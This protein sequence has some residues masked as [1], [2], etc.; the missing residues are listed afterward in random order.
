MA[1][2]R[3]NEGT[4]TRATSR[5]RLASA[6]VRA[7]WLRPKPTPRFWQPP[8][9]AKLATRKKS[10]TNGRRWQSM[11]ALSRKES[12][13]SCAAVLPLGARSPLHSISNRWTAI[14]TAA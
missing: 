13:L 11:L 7:G 5:S 12:A 14:E 6:G 8:R 9:P 4:R 2:V 10:N 1:E 3:L